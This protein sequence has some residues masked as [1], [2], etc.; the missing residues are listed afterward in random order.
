MPVRFVMA[1][2]ADVELLN[3]TIVSGPLGELAVTTSSS[4]YDPTYSRSGFAATNEVSA[5]LRSGT[6][7]AP[8]VSVGTPMTEGWIHFYVDIDTESGYQSGLPQIGFFD[9]N[10]AFLFGIGK[11]ANT[12]GAGATQSLWPAIFTQ[13]PDNEG[14]TLFAPGNAGGHYNVDINFRIA[15][16]G[17]WYVYLDGT[18]YYSFEGNTAALSRGPL[19]YIAFGRGRSTSA[20][21]W[22]ASDCFV[23]SQLIV[24]DE[25]T[26]GAKLY[27]L[28]INAE[29][30]EQQ[31]TGSHTDVNHVGV[32]DG[33]FVTSDTAAQEQSFTLDTPLSLP[34][35]HIIGG[36]FVNYRSQVEVDSTV[37][38]IQPYL[39]INGTQ[40][41]IGSAYGP[42]LTPPDNPQVIT[43]LTNPADAAAFGLADISGMELGFRSLA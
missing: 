23:F 32:N 20:L 2:P 28:A 17:Y 42:G 18:M 13:I 19:Q 37:T 14:P 24:A 33:T 21:A 16:D 26:I 36:V 39:R 6:G 11:Y 34:D 27:T 8:F 12:G 10:E 38:Q 41:N 40:Y 22:G 31:W 25:R 1:E 15:A 30:T 5:D 4:Y 7:D 35:G 9:D 43:L 29:G 3:D